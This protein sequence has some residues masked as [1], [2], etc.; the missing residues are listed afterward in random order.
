MCKYADERGPHCSPAFAQRLA[1]AEA[2]AAEVAASEAPPTSPSAAAAV[3]SAVS[4]AT[5]ALP[6]HG[7]SPLTTP[8]LRSGN[9][10]GGSAAF[11]ATASG[12]SGE[13]GRA[14]AATGAAG[15]W[16]VRAESRG[17]MEIKGKGLMETFDLLVDP[18]AL[19]ARAAA[20]GVPPPPVP[21]EPAAAA[22]RRPGSA[23]GRTPRHR[24]GFLGD[25]AGGVTGGRGGGGAKRWG[26]LSGVAGLSAAR[27]DELSGEQQAWLGSFRHR[28]D[29]RR[30][31]FGEAAFE[32]AFAAD[33]EP[34]RRQ[35]LLAGLGLHALAAMLQW[36]Q[37]AHPQ[38]DPDLS[39][40][41]QAG[42]EAAKATV[43]QPGLSHDVGV[44]SHELYIYI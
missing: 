28:I 42:L 7:L 25:G 5:T 44:S 3:T 11:S 23:H 2:A 4:V 8:T 32:A 41:G 6:S 29:V 37:V 31:A 13:Q 40:A 10:S 39:L 9:G 27:V 14:Q 21:D 16:F 35:W 1:A 19:A 12:G 34:G 20:L 26:F 17:E 24:P 43:R 38:F 18:A 33:A 22:S 15:G 36:H 30:M